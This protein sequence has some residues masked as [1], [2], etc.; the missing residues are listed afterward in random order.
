MK[1]ISSAERSSRFL[2]PPLLTFFLSSPLLFAPPTFTL[3]YSSPMLAGA[4]WSMWAGYRYS[5]PAIWIFS[6]FNSTIHAAMYLWYSC[7]T[8]KIP[9]PKAFKQGMTTAQ[10]T[11]L[12][13]GFFIATS[14]FYLRYDPLAYPSGLAQSAGVPSSYYSN[15]HNTLLSSS[16]T[17]NSSSF[18]NSSKT[19]AGLQALPGYSE[20]KEAIIRSADSNGT[21][22]CIQSSGALF[23]VVLNSIY[24]GPLI[25]LFVRFYLRSYQKKSSAK[26]E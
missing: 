4:M 24:L 5:A 8:L 26:K 20:A 11:Q 10:I 16:S 19:L 14:Y 13:V 15:M 9:V 3:A 6:Q 21:V 25:A 22:S 17:S 12:V 7:S 18:F 2:P 1:G 23:G